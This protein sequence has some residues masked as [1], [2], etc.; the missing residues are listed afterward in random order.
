MYGVKSFQPIVQHSQGASLG[1][2]AISR[3]YVP[4]VDALHPHLETYVQVSLS[5]DHRV[6]DGAVSARWLQ[7]FKAYL[8]KPSTMLL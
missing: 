6:V 8:E 7:L 3:R 5:C 2:G 4:G 1:V